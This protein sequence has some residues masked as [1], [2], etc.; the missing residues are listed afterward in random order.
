MSINFKFDDML[1]YLESIRL[2]PEP[3][4]LRE[5]AN[6]LNMLFK[7]ST[8]KGVLYTNNTDKIFFGVYVMPVINPSDIYN[9]II[10]DKYTRI[11]EYY[12][13][14]DSKLFDD[15]CALTSKEIL[16]I[17][18]ND[19]SKLIN[20]SSP[21]ELAVKEIDVYLDRTQSYIRQTDNIN[22]AGILTF[23]FKDLLH[24][25]TSIFCNNEGQVVYENDFVEFCGF[26]PDLIS[27]MMKLKNCEYV[28]I[29]NQGVEKSIIIAWVLKLYDNIKTLR[30]QTIRGLRKAIAY[31]QVRLVKNDMKRIITN[32]E[33]IDDSAL[34]E[35]FFSD[36]F[37]KANSSLYKTLNEYEG[38][39]F[40]LKMQANNIMDEDDALVILHSINTKI[41]IIDNYIDNCGLEGK[42]L[43]QALKLRDNFYKLREDLSQRSLYRKNYRRIYVNY[44]E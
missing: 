43:N 5:L 14:L 12:V 13:E 24:K 40:D 36:L 39:Y 21:I 7:D 34:L 28:S 37:K 42:T 20:S 8:C 31:S 18:L 44:P 22:Y 26:A 2:D 35:S 17:M 30:I 25:L 19:I 33:R 1:S 11:N 32:M 23:G 10:D 15:K 41:S 9:I 3:D 38:D 27:G 6:E 16:A 4:K 29:L